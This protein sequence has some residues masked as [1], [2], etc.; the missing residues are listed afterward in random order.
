M[1]G[2]PCLRRFI[3]LIRAFQWISTT[4]LQATTLQ[5]Y[6][7]RNLSIPTKCELILK[8]GNTRWNH[9]STD[10]CA[11]SI[12]FRPRYRGNWIPIKSLTSKCCWDMLSTKWRR[13]QIVVLL[14]KWPLFHIHERRNMIKTNKLLRLKRKTG[15]LLDVVREHYLLKD[16]PC[17]SEV[18]AVCEQGK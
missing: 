10:Q 14:E 17:H 1:E 15:R 13:V 9:N 2:C 11:F 16:V 7:H 8:R 3:H 5:N 6:F 18:C 12:C 4:L